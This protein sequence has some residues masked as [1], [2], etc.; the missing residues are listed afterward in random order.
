MGQR[1]PFLPFCWASWAATPRRKRCAFTGTWTCSL[2]PWRTGGTA[3]PSP[4]W[5]GK[6]R[7]PGLA[8]PRAHFPN[9]R[10]PFW[11]CYI[12]KIT[13]I[14]LS[15]SLSSTLLFYKEQ[16]LEIGFGKFLIC[17]SVIEN[18]EKFSFLITSPWWELAS[19]P[20][21]LTPCP[22]YSL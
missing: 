11:R 18:S 12:W 17:A 4:W 22:G 19:I 7:A 16:N 5:S 3:S 1:Y 21:V 15:L 9:Q 8:H 2:R 13:N 14:L 20:S 6:V 10:N